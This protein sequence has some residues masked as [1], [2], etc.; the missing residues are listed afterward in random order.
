MT[1]KSLKT[2]LKEKNYSVRGKNERSKLSESLN[3]YLSQ[4]NE[5]IWYLGLANEVAPYIKELNEQGKFPKSQYGK[6]SLEREVK[7]QIRRK[8]GWEIPI[9]EIPEEAKE[10]ISNE[11]M[12][13]YGKGT[14]RNELESSMKQNSKL[15]GV[16][17]IYSILRE[18]YGLKEGDKVEIK[19]PR[20]LFTQDNFMNYLQ[21]G[22]EIESLKPKES[23]NSKGVF[24]DN[25]EEIP[26]LIKYIEE[27]N[28][29]GKFDIEESN[30]RTGWRKTQQEVFASEYLSLVSRM[31]IAYKD[32]K[33]AIEFFEK[34]TGIVLPKPKE[35]K[36]F[37]F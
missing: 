35:Y 1:K 5:A 16:G 25:L 9:E 23:A 14:A 4:G 8:Y 18:F 15:F 2:I 33:K 6:K 31:S 12:K 19:S 22:R 21:R 10:E 29:T 11:Y 27:N 24:E 30:Y 28:R 26:K 3:E 34:E 32:P 7:H 20:Y 13:N 37:V 17:N 36:K